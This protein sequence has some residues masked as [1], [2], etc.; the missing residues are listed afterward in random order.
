M[1]RRVVCQL[2][3]EL[4]HP[5]YSAAR[6]KKPA[7]GTRDAPDDGGTFLT[8]HC[9]AMAWFPHERIDAVLRAAFLRVA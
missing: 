3:P 4:G 2:P 9:V 7:Y 8:R 6:L 5:P 1:N